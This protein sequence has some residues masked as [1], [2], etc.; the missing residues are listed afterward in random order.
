M[1]I[2]ENFIHKFKRKWNLKKSKQGT[3]TQYDYNQVIAE[4]A[5]VCCQVYTPDYS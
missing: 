4:H 2:D 1:N 5:V 3:K